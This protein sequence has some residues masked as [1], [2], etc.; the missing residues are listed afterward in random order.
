MDI[1]IVRKG[2]CAGEELFRQID[3]IG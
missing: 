1:D 2:K 3:S